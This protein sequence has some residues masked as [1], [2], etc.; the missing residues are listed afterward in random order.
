MNSLSG[1]TLLEVLFAIAIMAMGIVFL[2]DAQSRSMRMAAKGRNIVLASE[3]ARKKLADCKADLVD[4]GFSFTDYNEEGDFSDEG[5]DDFTWACYGT[6]FDMPV[7]SPELIA[8]GMKAQAGG[9]M[10]PGGEMSATMIAPFFGL[11]ATTLGDSARKLTAVIKWK[12]GDEDQ[13]MRVTTHVI[14][15]A[16][17]RKVFSVIPDK[18]QIPVR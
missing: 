8:Q 17:V 9:E 14:D 13:E 2:M 11:L 3:L 12:F 10:K 16:A 4:K 7:P 6:R 1:F 18:I 15:R 5:F